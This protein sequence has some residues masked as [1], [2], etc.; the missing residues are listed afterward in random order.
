MSCTR[1][2]G[3]KRRWSAF[4]TAIGLEPGLADAHAGLAG[5]L[6]DLGDLDESRKSLREAL[7][8]DPRHA[9]AWAR[10]ATRL[11]D[12]LPESDQAAIEELETDPELAPDQRWHL[13]F[14]LAHVVDGR[15]EFD[16]AAGLFAAANALQHSDF[17]ARGR[18]DDPEAH[19]AFVDR[20]IAKFTTEFFERVRGAGLDTERPVF[21]F[22][23][24]RSGTTLAE[25]ILAS[26]PRV[27]GAGELRLVRETFE[28]L[29]RASGHPDRAPLDCVEDIDP[30]PLR[31]LSLRHLGALGDPDSTM[32]RVVDKMP[33]NTL[34]LGLIAAMFPRAR[35][36]HCRRDLRDVAL[37]CWMTHFA[38]IR[39]ACDLDQIAS[40]IVE[41]HRVM[42]HWRRVLPVP[43]FDLEY[44]EMVADQEGVSRRLLDWCGLDWDPACLDFHKTRRPVR[45]TSVAQV[46]TPI[47]NSSV[48]RWKNYER[49]LAPSSRGW[50]ICRK[51]RASMSDR[52]ANRDQGMARTLETFRDEN[53]RPRESDSTKSAKERQWG[54]PVRRIGAGW[55]FNAMTTGERSLEVRVSLRAESCLK[56]HFAVPGAAMPINLPPRSGKRARC[57]EC[58]E[59]FRV[60]SQ[61]APA[62]DSVRPMT[63]SP[64]LVTPRPARPAEPDKIV[65]N[66]PT[67]GHGYRLA[68]Q[69]AGKQGRCTACRVIFTIPL[70]SPSSP[71]A[72]AGRGSE[73]SARDRSS[74]PTAA[75]QGPSSA[76]RNSRTGPGPE[77]SDRIPAPSPP[78]TRPSSGSPPGRGPAAGS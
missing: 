34:Y 63:A 29:P 64:R 24:P 60:P 47:Y 48:G 17:H 33:E 45:T 19:R 39:W 13:L 3:S 9:L 26:H 55:E 49:P 7:R 62:A 37:S 68:A 41:N 61:S 59:V 8:H 44:E 16:R 50:N 5:V 14:G 42:E 11:R 46:R 71:P 22:G 67:C 30:S 4:E 21:V 27:F 57:K 35:L 69:L 15:G 32:D 31:N 70:R 43:I 52:E 1:S 18:G 23:M 25:Q 53:E 51:V 58:H 38:E 40:R 36:I 66:C 65:F 78:R 74:G 12:K 2:A 72:A 75:G 28:S 73:A 20:L 76:G 56:S 77:P 10:L 6:E 54:N